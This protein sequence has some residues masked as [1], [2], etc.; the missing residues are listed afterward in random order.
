[1]L[2]SCYSKHIRSKFSRFGDRLVS[3]HIPCTAKP[4]PRSRVELASGWSKGTTGTNSNLSRLRIL[5]PTSMTSTSS[6]SSSTLRYISYYYQLLIPIFSAAISRHGDDPAPPPLKPS[7]PSTIGLE[8]PSPLPAHSSP[9][10]AGLPKPAGGALLLPRNSPRLDPL[11]LLG[12]FKP[13]PC[14]SPPNLT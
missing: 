12:L 10:S 9:T 1:M 13:P 14:A 8:P 3:Q 2:V 5:S 11:T 7:L 6:P 4:R